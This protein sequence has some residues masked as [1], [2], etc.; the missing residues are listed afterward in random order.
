MYKGLFFL[1]LVYLVF[2]L[3]GCSLP[4]WPGGK[5]P[6]DSRQERQ[7]T[8]AKTGERPGPGPLQVAEPAAGQKE[9]PVLT[10]DEHGRRFAGMQE[11]LTALVESMRINDLSKASTFFYGLD[12]A[13]IVISMEQLQQKVELLHPVEWRVENYRMAGKDSAV[14]EVSYTMPDGTVYRAKPFS[15][16]SAGDTW[17]VHFKSFAESFHSMVGHLLNR[18]NG[19]QKNSK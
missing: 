14:V 19:A 11:T 8:Q 5:E 12:E 1:A 10:P 6:A 18:E 17:A 9:N 15:M 7:E 13:G 2:A 4:K 3:A 16:L